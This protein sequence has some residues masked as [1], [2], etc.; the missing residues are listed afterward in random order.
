MP[1]HKKGLKRSHRFYASWVITIFLLL[2]PSSCSTTKRRLCVEY[3]KDNYLSDSE[4]ITT[5]Y[6]ETEKKCL[7]SCVRRE[8]CMA[9]N[10]HVSI[11]TCIL[12]PGVTCMAPD[13]PHGTG[14]LFVHLHLCKRRPPWFS[15][16]P[17]EGSWH[18]V[19]S[20][21]PSND[22]S[23]I[24]IPKNPARYVSRTLYQGYYLPGWW[25]DD[26][27][28]FRAVEPTTPQ[29]TKCP[30][31]EFLAVSASSSYWWV[32]YNAGES[33]PEGALPL[34]QLPDG[35]PL[36]SVKVGFETTTLC[37]F[38]NHLTNTTYF[39]NFAIYNPTAVDILCG[40]VL[41]WM[42]KKY[43]SD[44]SIGFHLSYLIS[45]TLWFAHIWNNHDGNNT[46]K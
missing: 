28:A 44:V 27:K 42:D 11:K 37:G 45:S 13:S 18:W 25:R 38:Y 19:T 21:H 7:V 29:V 10:Y 20:D 6:A 34:S 17:A 2:N 30:F 3:K 43:I 16:R 14:Y 12:M 32:S 4:L 23:I 5:L 33:L 40:T 9:F 8:P 26:K 22:V 1:F 41:K 39:V 15:V 35:T 31:G 36:Y 24:N 46:L